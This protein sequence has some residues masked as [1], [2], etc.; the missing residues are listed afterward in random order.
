M[1]HDAPL[2]VLFL[3]SV[4]TDLGGAER[5]A[6]GLATHLPRERIEPSFCF[7]RGAWDGP[8][9]A[10]QAADIPYVSLN[11]RSTWD[12]HR[13]L[14]LRG[15]LRRNR[16]D[17]LHSHLFGSNLWGAL[18]GRAAGVPVVLAHEHTWSYEGNPARAWLDGRVI[19]RLVTR[20][21]AVSPAD[22]ERMVAIEHV[23]EERVVVMPTA[24]I[25]RH[26]RNSVDLRSELG[27]A[28][29]TPVIATAAVLRAQKAL[30]VLLDA[31]AKVIERVPTACLVIAGDGP[32]RRFLEQHAGELRLNGNV[33][34]LGLRQDVDAIVASADIGAL[35]SDFE[36]MPLFAFE[37]MANRT[38]LV[39][40]TVGA[41]PS[42]V[43]DGATGVL[44]PPRDP[45]ALASALI[46]L[47]TDPGRRQAIASAASDRLD[48][49]RIDALA[50]RFAE[51]YE[52]LV[53]EARS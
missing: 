52:Q 51:L 22:A 26:Q 4:L 14:A 15:L 28:A 45:D 44:V 49:F 50:L 16:V 39:A 27:L 47:L 46:G 36:G 19:G 17:V 31:H 33:R 7:T 8:L 48:R 40:T 25:P 5:F 32:R 41:L 1:P 6:L 53:A 23:P 24:Y 2:K 37:C 30:E 21:I 3:I 13:I 18:M 34:F 38:P 42:M 9:E 20:F 29:D 43:E 12:V 11:R 35:S 10:L